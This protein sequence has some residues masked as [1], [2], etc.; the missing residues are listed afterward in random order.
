[1]VKGDKV[2]I[3]VDSMFVANEDGV[4]TAITDSELQVKIVGGK[5]DGYEITVTRLCS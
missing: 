3:K 5:Y 2:L 1:M 4:I